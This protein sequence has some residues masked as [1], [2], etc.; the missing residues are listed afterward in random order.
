MAHDVPH[1]TT[2]PLSIINRR[3]EE[4]GVAEASS[5]IHYNC[6]FLGYN[7]LA[8]GVLTGKYLENPPLWEGTGATEPRGRFDSRSVSQERVW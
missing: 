7:A 3:I 2:H 6:G 8:G 4:N 1:E 5:P